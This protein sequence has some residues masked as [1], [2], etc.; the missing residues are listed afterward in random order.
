MAPLPLIPGIPKTAAAI[1]IVIPSRAKK[2]KKSVT[3]GCGATRRLSN[4]TGFRTIDCTPRTMTP[5]TFAFRHRRRLAAFV[6]MCRCQHE[7][8]HFHP[9]GKLSVRLIPGNVSRAV[10]RKS[11]EARGLRP[12]P[13]CSQAAAPWKAPQ[14]FKTVERE[15]APLPLDAAEQ[16]AAHR[17][18][19]A[20]ATKILRL[21]TISA[22]QASPAT[23]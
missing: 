17:F 23:S 7:F 13:R 20:Q 4:A 8:S 11:D 14:L 21:R 19:L 6:F 3:A 1:K 10:C 5:V 18:Q 15:F 2:S 16:E 22:Q 9:Y 12:G